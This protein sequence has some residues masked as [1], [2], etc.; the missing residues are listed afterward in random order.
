MAENAPS[1]SYLYSVSRHFN[2]DYS[3]A[4][5]S[6]PRIDW[7]RAICGCSNSALQILIYVSQLN[8]LARKL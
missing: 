7:D 6:V 5:L 2:K 4:S 1:K 3:F 8:W